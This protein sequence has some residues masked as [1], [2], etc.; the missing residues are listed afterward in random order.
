M[1]AVILLNSRRARHEAIECA[2]RVVARRP[3]ILPYFLVE[4]IEADIDAAVEEF[5]E[6]LY[7]RD[8][9]LGPPS[10]SPWPGTAA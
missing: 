1:S 3:Y 6:D 7:R 2:S 10:D 5:L 4:R 8:R 9:D